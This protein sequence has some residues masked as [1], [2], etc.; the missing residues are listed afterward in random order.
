MVTYWAGKPYLEAAYQEA[1][2]Q[3]AY[4]VAFQEAYQ[5]GPCPA[6]AYPEEDPYPGET[7]PVAAFLGAYPAA[8]LESFRLYFKRQLLPGGILILGL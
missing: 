4:L 5:V 2:F 8:Y 3:G 6:G 1:P 7:C